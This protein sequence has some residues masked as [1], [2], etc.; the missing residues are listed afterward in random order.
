MRKLILW[1]TAALPLLAADTTRI[2]IRVTNENG[3]PVD[4]AAVTVRFKQGR[5]KIKMTRIQRSWDLR[6]SQEGIARL[7]SIPKGEIQ[8]FVTA[9]NHQTFGQTF[10][11]EEDERVIEVVLKPPQAQY[12]VHTQK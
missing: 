2:E 9:R 4:R 8:I 3:K 1:L 5:H 12:S 6:T 10:E 7:P 11:I